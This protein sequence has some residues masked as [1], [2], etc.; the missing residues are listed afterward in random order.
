M[1]FPRGNLQPTLQRALPFTTS[2]EELNCCS[3]S[4]TSCYW[5]LRCKPLCT[6]SGEICGPGHWRSLPPLRSWRL[7]SVGGGRGQDAGQRG[8]RGRSAVGLQSR[9]FLFLCLHLS[10]HLLGAGRQRLGAG[11]AGVERSVGGTEQVIGRSV[12][13]GF[14]AWG[15]TPG[16]DGAFLGERCQKLLHKTGRKVLQHLGKSGKWE[17]VTNSDSYYTVSV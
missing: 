15:L 17:T 2:S 14:F 1:H 3:T 12:Q 10:P 7:E 5:V 9:Q 6:V 16:V 13:G 11:C 4:M 8:Q